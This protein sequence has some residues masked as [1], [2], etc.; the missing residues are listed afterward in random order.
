VVLA[1][2]GGDEPATT[3]TPLED[4]FVARANDICAETESATDM[5]GDQIES[6]GLHSPESVRYL[7]AAAAAERSGLD[8]LRRLTPPSSGD[9]ARYE[10]FLRSYEENVVKLEQLAALIKSGAVDDARSLEEDINTSIDDVSNP[11]AAEL[12]I[13]DCASG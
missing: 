10:E 1:A 2:C 5:L 6:A 3:P 9:P 7:K 11:L 12:G 8:Q 13:D 4:T